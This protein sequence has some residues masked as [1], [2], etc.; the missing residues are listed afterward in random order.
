MTD[1]VHRQALARAVLTTVARSR[2]NDDPLGSLAGTVLRGE[3]DL[4]T[5]LGVSWHGR[6]LEDA[7]TASLA[8]RDAMSADERA[9]WQRQAQRLRDSGPALTADVDPCDGSTNDGREEWR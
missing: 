2:G 3:A 1:E 8:E 5:A 7:F 9:E 4:R 6:A